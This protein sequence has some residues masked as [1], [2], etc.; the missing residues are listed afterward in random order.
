MKSIFLKEIR[1]FFS[2]LVGYFVIVLFLL[3]AGLFMWVMPDT[4]IP[5]FGYA[6]MDRFF[7]FAPWLLIFLIPAITMRTFSDEFKSGTIEFL[8]T[9]PLQNKDII[10][11][12][13][14]AS[15]VLVII[16]IL[17]TL[18]YVYSISALAIT[19]HELDMGSI[20]G[21]YLGL[22]FLVAAFTSIGLF[23]SAST[24]NQIIA[25]L[26]SVFVSFL[27]YMGFESVSKLPFFAG[28][29]DYYISQ[30]GMTFHYNSISRGVLD[31]RDLVYFLSI[32]ALF[33]LGTNLFL[34]KRNWN[35]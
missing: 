5:D 22:L 20:I 32:S 17:P 21:S 19:N 11:G 12:K 24:E 33:L 10:L 4:N 35:G 26:L 25:F 1:S 13:F 6:S 18:L 28:M 31:S 30:F 2:S 8:A 14:F 16:S 3:V 34:Q 7:S 9:K 15:F 29:L 27:L 23:C